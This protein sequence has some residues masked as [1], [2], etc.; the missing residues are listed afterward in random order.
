MKKQKVRIDYFGKEIPYSDYP[1]MGM[2]DEEIQQMDDQG[3]GKRYIGLSTYVMKPTLVSDPEGRLKRYQIEDEIDKLEEIVEHKIADLKDAEGII[4][5][6]SK[7]LGEIGRLLGTIG[8]KY[9]K[10]K[11][12][13]KVLDAMK[14]EY[15]R[16]L[17]NGAPPLDTIILKSQGELKKKI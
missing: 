8:N 16:A 14:R 12:S 6:F 4:G 15:R 17:K 1:F 7:E 2:T 13:R 3:Y 9:K 5:D 11:Y 10:V